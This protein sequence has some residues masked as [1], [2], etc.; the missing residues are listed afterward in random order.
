MS[1]NSLK[2][3]KLDKFKDIRISINGTG[4]VFGDYDAYTDQETYQYSLRSN[5]AGA[6][7]YLMEKKD[8][9]KF[10]KHYAAMGDVIASTVY[11]KDMQMM[12]QLTR[13]VFNTWY[14]DL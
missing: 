13:I 14:R 11:D 9:L 12:R 6:T 3:T 5:H 4:Y 2:K 10:A 1:L 8:F 7:C